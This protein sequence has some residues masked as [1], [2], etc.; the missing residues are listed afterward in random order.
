[1]GFPIKR[2]TEVMQI[3]RVKV[4]LHWSVLLVGT[5]VLFGAV[6]RP[7]ETLV[8]WTCY[9]AVLLIHECGHM[10][11]AQRKG[12]H[13][14]AIELYPIHGVVRFSQPWSRYDEA[15]IAWGGV[16]AQAIVGLPLVAW[17]S[18]F[19]FTRYSP[20]NAGI[21]I[22]GYFSLFVALFNLLPI[23]PLDG[24]KA[25]HV[26]GARF[27]RASRKEDRREPSWRS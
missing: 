20:L 25:W 17:I 7:A 9:F 6:E 13:V 18:I 14:F 10:I 21:G 1:M 16:L 23:A 22:L 15:V 2:L 5:L 27:K 3:R 12:C 8:A 19:G 24:S 4:Y 26:I 11:L